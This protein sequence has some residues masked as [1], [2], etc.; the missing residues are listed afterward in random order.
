[1]ESGQSSNST[2]RRIQEETQ[3]VQARK[4]RL[5]PEHKHE[6]NTGVDHLNNRSEQ[7]E[8]SIDHPHRPPI[9][10]DA[11]SGRKRVAKA[12]A[13]PPPV[14][15]ELIVEASEGVYYEDP[16]PTNQMSTH[17]KSEHEAFKARCV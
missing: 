11:P 6:K 3:R 9:L 13:P 17:L 1:M 16:V 5:T 10:L 7:S 2:L 8:S 14:Q 15:T 4:K 12:A